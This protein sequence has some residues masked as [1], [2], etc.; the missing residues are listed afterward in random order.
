LN[1]RRRTKTNERFVL[2]YWRE[3]AVLTDEDSRSV[4]LDA[5]RT[6]THDLYCTYNYII[7][8]EL[9]DILYG[10]QISGHHQFTDRH[11]VIHLHSV[12]VYTYNNYKNINILF[13]SSGSGAFSFS[14]S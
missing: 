14:L 11:N 12:N 4:L 8:S 2:A 6:K 5:R 10:I 3:E 7:R 1:V 13:F 9:A